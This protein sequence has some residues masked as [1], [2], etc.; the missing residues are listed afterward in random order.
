MT[1]GLLIAGLAALA[2][3][4]TAGGSH[5]PVGPKTA[6]TLDAPDKVPGPLA[7]NLD[8]DWA[9]GSVAVVKSDGLDKVPGPLAL[10]KSDELDKT[11]GPVAVVKSDEL[12]RTFGPVALEKGPSGSAGL[13]AV[14]TFAWVGQTYSVG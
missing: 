12:D 7:L 13:P 1:L 8:V 2:L 4:V 5:D 14:A 11:F 3:L 10:V 6:L 9:S